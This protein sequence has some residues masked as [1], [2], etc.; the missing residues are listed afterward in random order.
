MA[1]VANKAAKGRTAAMMIFFIVLTPCFIVLTPRDGAKM[2]QTQI[3]PVLE[4]KRG[5]KLFNCES[6]EELMKMRLKKTAEI[7]RAVQ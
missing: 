4:T 5:V 6:G 2:R 3:N 1:E 7:L